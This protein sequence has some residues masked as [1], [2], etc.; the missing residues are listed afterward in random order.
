ME[1]NSL[2]SILRRELET[3]L[4]PDGVTD[5]E[6]RMLDRIEKSFKKAFNAGYKAAQIFSGE[7]W[8]NNACQ[9]Y[10]VLAAESLGY[11]E[12]QT[13]KLVRRINSYFDSTSIEEAKRAYE[14]SPY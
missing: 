3:D 8:S 1:N 10:S 2:V 9:G 6:I 14:K 5:D 13:M 4:F 12:D 7:E 11:S